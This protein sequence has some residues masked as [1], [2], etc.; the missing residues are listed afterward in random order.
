MYDIL[1]FR[2]PHCT[3]QRQEKGYSEYFCI[4]KS[5]VCNQHLNPYRPT[6]RDT[7]FQCHPSL[8]QTHNNNK[9]EEPEKKDTMIS[10]GCR[11]PA[12]II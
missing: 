8:E 9:K 6:R 3:N 7:N 2:E 5:F 12:A 10:P 11:F 4:T 1:F